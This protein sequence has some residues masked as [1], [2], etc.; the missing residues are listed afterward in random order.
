VQAQAPQ[1]KSIFCIREMQEWANRINR[2]IYC[3][4]PAAGRD[5]RVK[6]ADVCL[7]M[8]AFSSTGA[9]CPIPPLASLSSLIKKDIWFSPVGNANWVSN[10]H[11][12]IPCFSWLNRMVF[13]VNYHRM[14]L[15]DILDFCCFCRNEKRCWCRRIWFRFC[16]WGQMFHNIYIVRYYCLQYSSLQTWW[17]ENKLAVRDTRRPYFPFS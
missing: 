3:A 5:C 4:V 14:I 6:Q 11:C 12:N 10:I 7:L 13:L 16:Y 2:V 1:H 15:Y 9:Q 8:V 17:T